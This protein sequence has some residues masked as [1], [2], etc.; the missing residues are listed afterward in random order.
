MLS[1]AIQ[2]QMHWPVFPFLKAGN[3]TSKENA[4]IAKQWQISSS[5]QCLIFISD[6]SLSLYSCHCVWFAADLFIKLFLTVYA[7]LALGIMLF[8]AEVSFS[9]ET[10]VITLWKSGAGVK[11]I[12]GSIRFLFTVDL[13][14]SDGVNW[15]LDRCICTIRI[16]ICLHGWERMVLHT[17]ICI[18]FSS[19]LLQPLVLK[20]RLLSIE[21]ELH[22]YV[23]SMLK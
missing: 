19:W 22:L 5:F 2:T 10:A 7:S 17:K 23:G 3:M 12:L 9:S 13:N 20:S 6:I 1:E 16:L 14:P 15:R 21:L 11:A 4:V 8:S 18:G